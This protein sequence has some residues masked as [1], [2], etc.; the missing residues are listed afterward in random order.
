[1]DTAVC[2]FWRIR[3]WGLSDFGLYYVCWAGDV[4]IKLSV[5]WGHGVST[6][7]SVCWAHD[8]RSGVWVMV[9]I[10]EDVTVY[11]T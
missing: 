9:D 5:C 4:S 6:K 7:L 3:L 10:V 2:Y 8:V 1:M 11:F